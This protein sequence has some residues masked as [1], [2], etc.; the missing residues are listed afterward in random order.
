MALLSRGV[1]LNLK[2]ARGPAVPSEVVHL[3]KS[4]ATLRRDLITIPTSS[5]R[6]RRPESTPWQ[7]SLSR[8]FPR[9][10]PCRARALQLAPAA[11]ACAPATPYLR[12]RTRLRCAR[13]LGR[14]VKAGRWVARGNDSRT[15]LRK[16]P[17]RTGGGAKR[18]WPQ[19]GGGA[20]AAGRC[21]AV[22]SSFPRALVRTRATH[23]AGSIL[24][25]AL[26]TPGRVS[27]P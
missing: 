21:C 12:L 26:W 23:G 24:W 17:G 3:S 15:P 7:S 6:A 8:S 14:E 18:G 22:P 11:A 9:C 1:R 2:I 5:S 20:G 4:S 19:R 25:S 13:P 16:I 10:A 27:A